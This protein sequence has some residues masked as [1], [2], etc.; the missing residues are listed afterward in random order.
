VSV[1]YLKLNIVVR[2]LCSRNNSSI[3]DGSL[4][5]STTIVAVPSALVEQY[6][7]SGS[8][9][10]SHVGSLFQ[11]KLKNTISDK[12]MVDH[13]ILTYILTPL[14]SRGKSIE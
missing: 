6:G 11:G 14:G 8:Q 10:T 3:P 7:A 12:K 2:S 4:R 5:G 13:N 1:V 9:R